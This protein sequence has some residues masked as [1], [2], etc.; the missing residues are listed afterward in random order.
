MEMDMGVCMLHAVYYVLH[1]LCFY[2]DVII[3]N[4]CYMLFMIIHTLI[5]L[6]VIML[7]VCVSGR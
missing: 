4:T 7:P 3:C 6:P 1:A 5:K 2:Y